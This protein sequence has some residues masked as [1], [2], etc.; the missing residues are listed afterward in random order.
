MGSPTLIRSGGRLRH[1]HQHRLIMPVGAIQALACRHPRHPGVNRRW[2]PKCGPHQAGLRCRWTKRARLNRGPRPRIN[3]HRP[4]GLNRFHGGTQL[5]FISFMMDQNPLALLPHQGGRDTLPKWLGRNRH[6]Q[7]LKTRHYRAILNLLLLHHRSPSQRVLVANSRRSLASSA[8]SIT[9]QPSI[10]RL[11]ISR[12]FLA[13]SANSISG[14]GPNVR[15]TQ[16]RKYL[17]LPSLPC[18]PS[19]VTIILT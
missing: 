6:R 19:R 12:R 10:V 3:R 11:A 2:G 16:E 9:C 14:L 8:N 18:Q 1:S 15:L 13:S 17:P 7:R 4:A 5:R